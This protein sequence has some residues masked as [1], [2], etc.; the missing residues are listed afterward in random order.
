VSKQHHGLRS[1]SLWEIVTSQAQ[2]LPFVTGAI[3]LVAGR[4]AGMY[5]IAAGTIA[6]FIFSV[7]NAWALLVEILR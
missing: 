2:V 1:E 3:L 4:P 5:W 7:L 6:I